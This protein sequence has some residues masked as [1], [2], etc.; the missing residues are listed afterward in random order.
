MAGQLIGKLDRLF[1]IV[2]LL[3]LMGSGLVLHILTA[4]TLKSYYGDP[5]GYVSFVL[6]V[7]SE[8]Y[9]VTVQLADDMYNYTLLFAAFL[10]LAA[11]AGGAWYVKNIIKLRMASL[12]EPRS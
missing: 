5:W 7:L 8:A 6:P 10:C 2:T 4:L 1:N 3:L 11:V 9:L 12:L